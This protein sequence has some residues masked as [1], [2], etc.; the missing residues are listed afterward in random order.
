VN[1]NG[2]IGWRSSR[3]ILAWAE[4][5]GL[6]TSIRSRYQ[7]ISEIVIMLMMTEPTTMADNNEQRQ[8]YVR[9]SWTRHNGHRIN[10]APLGQRRASD[11]SSRVASSA[12][13]SLTERP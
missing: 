4:L 3:T 13:R 11:F 6:F 9:T 12:S 7:S 5:N 8:S 1:R 10:S 2:G